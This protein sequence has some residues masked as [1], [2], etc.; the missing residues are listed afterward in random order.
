MAVEYFDREQ[1]KPI[2]EL[3]ETMILD[4]EASYFLVSTENLTRKI[5]LLSVI[6]M[7]CGDDNNTNS[8]FK[9]YST[10]YLN[11]K[12]SEILEII[13]NM[14]SK[15]DDYTEMIENL[16]TKI[17]ASISSFENIVNQ[18][19]PKLEDLE[20]RLQQLINEKC[21]ELAQEHITINNRITSVEEAYQNADESILAYVKE[22]F[23]QLF[24]QIEEGGDISDQMFAVLQAA[25]DQLRQDLSSIKKSLEAKDSELEQRIIRLENLI[26]GVSDNM[27]SFYY[28][29]EEIDAFLN[30]LYKRITVQIISSNTDEQG[31]PHDLNNYMDNGLFFFTLSSE[32]LNLPPGAVNGLLVVIDCGY[33]PSPVIKQLFFR[34]GTANKTDHNISIRTRMSASAVWTDWAR[35]LTSK[36]II[37]GTE[38]PTTLE[39]GQ[40][41]LQYFL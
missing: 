12:V 7:M 26:S 1:G 28:N 36:D 23:E 33:E 39:T 5:N 27:N 2:E 41:Y 37:Y 40:I 34:Y 16:K 9:F 15:F 19:D 18:I 38:V 22:Q 17:D 3:E 32:P 30:D 4:D 35:I 11:S 20:Q 10:N 13:N 6:K 25:I 8:E 24:K 29:K 31:N 14:D 21:S